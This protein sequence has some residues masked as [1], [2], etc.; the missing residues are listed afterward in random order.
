MDDY[1]EY[2]IFTDDS[3][4]EDTLNIPGNLEDILNGDG[5]LPEGTNPD[6]NGENPGSTDTPTEPS[7]PGSTG[8]GEDYGGNDYD[9]DYGYGGDDY[10]SEVVEVIE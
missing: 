8:G 6:N 3:L 7:D 4:P 10:G 9:V 2:E 5:T 1:D